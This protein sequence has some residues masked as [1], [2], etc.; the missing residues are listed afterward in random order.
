M[1]F[2]IMIVVGLVLLHGSLA[3]RKHNLRKNKGILSGYGYLP[4][5]HRAGAVH[6]R[7][8]SAT[9]RY[10]GTSGCKSATDQLSNKTVENCMDIFNHIFDGTGVTDAD[11][12]TYCA[13]DDCGGI[14]R[15][16]FDDISACC[17]DSVVSLTI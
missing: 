11:V 16:V 5:H 4:Q 3:D 14:V 7:E 6:Q 12:Q 17:G 1:K 15:S 2:L 8:R 10:P 13:T 9:C